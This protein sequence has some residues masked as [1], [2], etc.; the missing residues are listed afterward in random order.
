MNEKNTF[1]IGLLGVAIAIIPFSDKLKV[2]YVDLGFTSYSILTLF[3]ITFILLLI[4]LYC[5]ALDNIRYGIQY[6]ETLKFF[7]YLQIAA[8][9]SYVIS[10]ISPL[11]FIMVWII[12]K[13]MRLLP[14]TFINIE[15]TTNVVLTIISVI[16]AVFSFYSSYRNYISNKQSVEEQLDESGNNLINEARQLVEKKLWNLAIVEGFR[17]VEVNVN[18]KLLEYGIDGLRLPF[19]RLIKILDDYDVLSEEDVN[20]LMYVKELRNKAVHSSATFT[21][22]DA[23]EVIKIIN[24]I[25]PKLETS[26]TSPLLYERKVIDALTKKEG[27][28]LPHHLNISDDK[29]DRSYDAKAEGP[30]FE[31][32]IEVKMTNKLSIIKHSINRLRRFCTD[33]SRVIIVTPKLKK[34][35]SIDENNL[36]LLY[37]DYETDSFINFNEIYKWIY[38]S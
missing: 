24:Q 15:I 19:H 7:K 14:S 20:R 13:V 31:Y 9:T 11:F 1:L 4:S 6:L 32:F 34:D 21:K 10:I 5:Y 12:V 27:L 25:L 16:S 28:F 36:R 17:S 23:T 30:D 8:N 3:F 33:K 18:K 35:I 22:N 2:I 38:P 37:Y 26:T 29:I